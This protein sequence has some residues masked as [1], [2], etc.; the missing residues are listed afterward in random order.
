MNKILNR[1][2][3]RIPWTYVIILILALVIT[4]VAKIFISASF[5]VVLFGTFFT[6]G[7]GFSL[8]LLLR[9]LYW[10]ITKKGDYEKKN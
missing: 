8:F 2:L 4:L 9:Q 1:M 3:S 7:F 5:A 6:I 10:F